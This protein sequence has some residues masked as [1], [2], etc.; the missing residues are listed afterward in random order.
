MNLAEKIHQTAISYGDKPAIVFEGISYSF[1]NIDK[2][3]G[4]YASVLKQ[5]GI[6]PGIR[7]AFQLDKCMEFIFLHLANLSIGGITLPLNSGYQTDE[8]EYFL[9]D[10]ESSLFVTDSKRYHTHLPML[11][12]IGVKVAVIN[13]ETVTGAVNLRGLLEKVSTVTE[14]HN[15]PTGD[16][17]VAVICY[18]SG[19]TGRSKGA[20][21]THRNLIANMLDL[22]NIWQWTENDILLH[23]LPLFHVHGLFVALHGSLYAGST[24]I[25]HERFE[26]DRT[27]RTMVEEN[28]TMMMGVPTVYQRLMNEWDKLPAKP[29]LSSMRVFIS[30]SAPLSINLFARFEKATG[31]RLLER[32]GMTETGMNTSNTYDPTGRKPGSVGFPLPGV[33]LRVIDGEGKDVVPGEIGEMLLKGDNVFKGYWQMPEKTKESFVDGWFRSGD[34]GYQDPDDEMRVYLSGRAKELIISGGYN[35]YPKEVETVLETHAAVKECAV[36]GLFDEDFGEKVT[37]A[38]VLQD[39]FDEINPAEI[40][41]FC[42]SKLAVFKCPK[43]I[44][45]IDELPR[46]AMGKI[47]KNQLV[48][49]YKR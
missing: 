40:I 20:M 44:H 30:G 29:D 41:T 31:F 17:D 39:G 6:G 26:P 2:E 18:T 33:S 10:S 34:L 35:V 7:V 12:K 19:T 5:L 47:Q 36:V 27:W 46:N 48:E 38:V 25:M 23:I 15:F 22:K 32:Y 4:R 28:C 1:T 8:V 45:F 21:I 3:V 49:R 11:E 42:R 13:N 16:D 9:S 24:V 14:Q 37:A 43:T